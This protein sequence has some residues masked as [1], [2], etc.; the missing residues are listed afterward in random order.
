MALHSERH[1][2][3]LHSF[4]PLIVGKLEQDGDVKIPARGY[5]MCP[6]FRHGRDQV[7]LRPVDATA[8]RKYD[9]IFYRRPNGKYVL[10]RVVGVKK[11][12]YVLRGDGQLLDEYPVPPEWVIARVEG[13]CRGGRDYSCAH[14][15]HR[16]YAVVWVHTVWVRRGWA[17]LRGG[18]GRL[19]GCVLPSSGE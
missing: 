16:V 15:G 1:T 5:S 8:L 4:M 9:I 12:G 6:L 18:L 7:C 17:K 10:H 13:F 11:D 2:A 14:W 3:P 19:K